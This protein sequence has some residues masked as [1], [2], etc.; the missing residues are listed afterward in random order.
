[1]VQELQVIS[2]AFNAE[3]GQAMSGIVNITTKSRFEKWGGSLTLYGGDYLTQ[4]SDIFTGLSFNPIQTKNAEF[5][6]QGPIIKDR[7]DVSFTTRQVYW[8]GHQRG[9][10]RY[11][12]WNYPGTIDLSQVPELWQNYGADSPYL[13]YSM[14]DDAAIDSLILHN[15]ITNTY[16][17]SE[18][19]LL[20]NRADYDAMPDSL[21]DLYG[22]ARAQWNTIYKDPL[23]DGSITPMQWNQR[24][25]YNS[26]VSLRLTDKIRLSMQGS[27]T[28]FQWQDYDRHYRYNPY[29]RVTHSNESYSLLGKLVHSISSKTFYNLGVSLSSKKYSKDNADGYIV[30]PELN[31]APES[32]SFGFGGTD[33]SRF[34]RQTM[35]Q[36][37]KF[38]LTNQ[39]NNANQLKF[40]LEAR[41]HNL[42]MKNYSL[43]PPVDRQILNVFE[44]PR[45]TSY[46][47]PSDPADVNYS[48]YDHSPAEYSA[49]IQDK[50]ELQELI[51]NMG[52][53]FDYF[54][55]DGDIP[56]DPS[57]PSI[58]SPV[59]LENLWNDSNNDG[60]YGNAG[61]TEKTLAQ[62]E[63]YWFK[64]AEAKYQISPRFGASFPI[65]DQ[66]VIHV[67][68]GHFLQ[69]PRFEL[70]YQNPDYELGS[71][72]GNVGLVGNPDLKPEKTISGEIG[73]KQE[74]AEG[75]AVDV[76]AYFRDI[77]DLVG[78]RN[79]EIDLAIAGATYSRI[80]NSDFAYIK[81]LVVSFNY[82][83]RF[84]LY[85]N[86]DY[87]FQVAKGSASDP[88]EARNAANA[89]TLPEIY[90]TPLNWDQTHTI[91]LNMGFDRGFWGASLIGAFGS[92]MP[93]TPRFATSSGTTDISS[94]LTNSQIKPYQINFDL[95]AYYSTKLMG[96]NQRWFLRVN[97]IFDRLNHN[98]VYAES[99]KADFSPEYARLSGT[100]FRREFVNSL[101]SWFNDET[102][103][104]APRRV[105]MGVTFNF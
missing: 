32:Y 11:N 68:Y 50:I 31:I 90:L 29:G 89:G 49:Y 13:F 2:G 45:M 93:Y 105:E 75:L 55:P 51:I 25:F 16:Q 95:N 92:G 7:L 85:G 63:A 99:G 22:L 20:L 39:F 23:G 72:T 48:A 24:A 9:E 67:S 47:I 12:P 87:T 64:E 60:I 8:E 96:F 88:E 21:A 57:D 94:I 79:A 80:E 52:V 30:Y 81:G 5:S 100:I 3:Y 27:F 71:G 14:G 73:L 28:D 40:G 97:N 74:I 10:H 56:A 84:G 15:F 65:T 53:R 101:E 59:K 58:Y 46:R 43:L 104:S 66:G 76:T 70:L 78:T 35:T 1:M 103:Y 86:F 17:E 91:N 62:R 19:G 41:R 33:N 38:D 37:V 54:N 82:N 36:L 98:D 6:V 18:W 61:D 42:T 44:D 34:E 77:R 83:S 102:K 4:H 26:M 69:M